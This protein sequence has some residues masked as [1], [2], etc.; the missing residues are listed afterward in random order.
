[1]KADKRTKKDQT[2]HQEGAIS[3]KKGKP[4]KSDS[5]KPSLTEEQTNVSL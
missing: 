4:R 1:M 2:L 3:L 5:W